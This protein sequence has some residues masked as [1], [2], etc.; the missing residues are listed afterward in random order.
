VDAASRLPV[1]LQVYIMEGRSWLNGEGIG[2]RRKP[3][4]P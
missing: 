4:R 3:A 2:F 1:W